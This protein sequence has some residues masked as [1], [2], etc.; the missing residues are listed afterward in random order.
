MTSRCTSKWDRWANTNTSYIYHS[1]PLTRPHP[2]LHNETGGRTLLTSI[3]SF[4]PSKTILHALRYTLIQTLL[5]TLEHT[6]FP[7]EHTPTLSFFSAGERRFD[8]YRGSYR[9]QHPVPVLQGAAHPSPN[10]RDQRGIATGRTGP[11]ALESWIHQR[12]RRREGGGRGWGGMRYHDDVVCCVMF[13]LW[14]DVSFVTC[15]LWCDVG[16]C[17]M[18]ED[19]CCTFCDVMGWIIYSY[20][21][22]WLL[23]NTYFY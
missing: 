12:C 18:L 22:V 4:T 11:S 3:L 7:S 13:T 8:P 19:V 23:S 6:H 5:P 15:F 20:I 21:E 2:T 9:L 10:S 1:Y 16:G 17:A 14:R